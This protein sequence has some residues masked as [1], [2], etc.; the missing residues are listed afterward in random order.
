M[1]CTLSGYL[2]SARGSKRRR[3]GSQGVALG[4]ERDEVLAS[5]GGRVEELPRAGHE[6]SRSRHCLTQPLRAGDA[7][8]KIHFLLP[9][10][11]ATLDRSMTKKSDTFARL[12]ASRICALTG[13]RPQT[14]DAWVERGLL[15]RAEAYGELDVIEQTVVKALLTTV[16]KSQVD[17]VWQ[18]TRPR[19]RESVGD[20]AR[21]LVW[22][23]NVRRVTITMTETEL[24]AAVRH[25]RP[26]H[27]LPLGE[28]VL[29]AR[30][31]YRAEVQAARR[32]AAARAGGP[33][34]PRDQTR[35]ARRRIASRR[36]RMLSAAWS[37][38][39]KRLSLPSRYDGSR[40]R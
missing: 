26:V 18:E 2:P 12:S 7:P 29:E 17:L 20:A 3:G 11:D 9:F 5:P 34:A 1:R 28:L 32:A 19:L 25:G 13:V 15:R 10:F 24:G 31:V 38:D 37:V 35:R 23:P 36:V 33:L 39:T 22:D 6:R 30:R 16:P 8:S 40:Q 27:A 14:R 4:T 21:T